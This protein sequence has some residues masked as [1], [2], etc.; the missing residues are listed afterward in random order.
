MGQVNIHSWLY[1][2]ETSALL[3]AEVGQCQWRKIEAASSGEV[4]EGSSRRFIQRC[5]HR[6][7]SRSY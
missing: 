3:G 5:G 1:H 4:C 7:Q 6:G 2:L